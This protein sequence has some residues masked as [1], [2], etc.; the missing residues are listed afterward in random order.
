MDREVNKDCD[1]DIG[2]EEGGDRMIVPNEKESRSHGICSTK[3]TGGHSDSTADHSAKIR[4]RNER[5]KQWL[6]R[7]REAKK[8]IRRLEEELRE[9]MESQESASA[10]GYS[11][12]PKGSLEQSDLSDYLVEREKVWRKIQ[13][14]RYK[15]IMVFQEIKSAIDRLPSADERMVMS[16]RYLELNGYKEKSWEEI[17]VITGH[18]WRQTHYIHSKALNNIEKI[19]NNT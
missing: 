10:I 6:W 8:D 3:G 16:C 14:A 11:D 9:L 15:R 1:L 7:Y 19:R 2:K 17:C 12:M 4:E 5:V 13:K 18:E